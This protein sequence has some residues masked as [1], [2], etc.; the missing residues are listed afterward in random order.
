VVKPGGAGRH[1]GAPVWLT[2]AVRRVL[3]LR[4]GESA[5]NVEGRWQ[6]WRDVALTTL[7]EAQAAA[8][9]RSLSDERVDGVAV[10]TS[11][12]R[13]AARTAE[14]LARRLGLS[15]ATPMSG[16]RERHGGEWEGHT[17]A[18]IDERWPGMRAAW[19]RGDLAAPP[20]GESD[21]EL[22][23][24]FDAALH[25]A[26]AGTDEHGVTLVVTHH[27]VLRAASTR[28]GVAVTTLIPNLGGRWFLHDGSAL[29]AGDELAPLPAV[30]ADDLAV[31]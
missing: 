2:P 27:G 10:F 19:R 31:E 23:A 25:E 13:R 30:D 26:I 18:E 21:A 6:G 29:H 22:L 11:D 8:R 24:R 28:A 1:S 7:G 20:G 9:A 4:H 16:F 14:I 17:A 12:L 5:W 15:G 3:V